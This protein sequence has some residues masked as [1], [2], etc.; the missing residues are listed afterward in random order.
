M[1]TF[2]SCNVNKHE[3]EQK[4]KMVGNMNMQVEKEGGRT[5]Q[6][7]DTLHFQALLMLCV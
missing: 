3:P 6:K 1:Q 7:K 2:A 4:K 5:F